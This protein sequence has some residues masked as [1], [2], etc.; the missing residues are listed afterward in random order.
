MQAFK[1]KLY[2]TKRTKHIDDMLREAAFTWN[3]ALAMQK[4]YYS[5]YGKYINRCHLQKWF[6]KRYKRHYLGSQVRQE[7]IERL[8]TAYNR[9]FKKLAQRPPKF[10]KTAEF[11]SIVYKQAGYKLYG[12]ELILNRKFRF[13]FSKSR[14]YEGNIKRV[15]VKRSRVNEYYVVIVTDANPKTYRK[16]HNGASVGIDFGL[17]MYL[18]ISDG[19]EYSNPL[20][21]KQHLSEIRKK[22]RNLSKCKNDSNNRKKKRIELAKLHEHLHN[23]REDYQ[24]KLSHEL[25]RKYDYI[26]IEDLCLTGITKMWGRKMNDLAHAAF[27][28]KLEYVASK[29]GVVVHKIDRWYASS[30]TCECG[31]VNK[32]LQL[33]D[34]EWVCP[35][36]GS[37][38]HRDLNAAKNILRKGISELDSMSK[39]SSEASAL[40]P[41]IPLALAVGVCQSQSDFKSLMINMVANGIT[42][43]V[44]TND[45]QRRNI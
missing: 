17:K 7:I 35:E 43:R 3:K 30:K 42:E 39:T 14:E 38:N 18:T 8:D 9:F 26:F 41:R 20:F 5:L 11:V 32:S 25:C 15:I 37:I 45:Q 6:D 19:R 24:F 34:R 28:N 40:Y 16:T 1:Y 2:K 27:I 31:Y 4:R 10:K 23:K 13:K 29:Y 21:L 44:E 33:I 12:N 36:C 22:S